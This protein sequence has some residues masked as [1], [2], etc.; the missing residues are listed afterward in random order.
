M[1]AT[2]GFAAREEHLRIERDWQPVNGRREVRAT[3]AL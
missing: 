1:D 3:V 2:A